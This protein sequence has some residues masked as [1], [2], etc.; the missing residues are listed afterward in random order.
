MSFIEFSPAF[1]S[2]ALTEFAYYN[3]AGALSLTAG[4]YGYSE[5]PLIGRHAT[6]SAA[7]NI[8]A[9][10]TG[11]KP[12]SF[13]TVYPGGC[14]YLF[15]NLVDN[16][17]YYAGWYQAD[18]GSFASY[19]TVVGDTL[20]LTSSYQIARNSGT[21]AWFVIGTCATLGNT[22]PY[23]GSPVHTM[24]GSVGLAGSGADLEMA[25]LNIIAGQ[26]YRISN[27]KLKIPTSWSY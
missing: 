15:G 20:T 9:V 12:L 11:I 17:N 16:S 6:G 27:L 10:Y 7:V 19:S 22:S 5:I 1:V 18:R 14:T 4:I 8:F 3:K 23:Y 25:D 26:P 21:A 2:S 24:I 13:T